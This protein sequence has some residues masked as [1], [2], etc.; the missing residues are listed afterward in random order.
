M[1][2]GIKVLIPIGVLLCT[3]S[4]TVQERVCTV[5]YKYY[6][7]VWCRFSVP[8]TWEQNTIDEEAGGRVSEILVNKWTKNQSDII[9]Q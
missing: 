5:Q 2:I 9:E 1:R 3:E 4:C 7:S 8:G 6:L